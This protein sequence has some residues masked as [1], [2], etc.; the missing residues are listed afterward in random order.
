MSIVWALTAAVAFVAGGVAMKYSVGLTRPG[1]SLL[2]FVLFCAGAA[3]QTLAMRHA[4][5][6]VTY[7]VVLG[8]ESI[9]AFGA[10]VLV[11][12][13]PATPVRILAAALVAVGVML[14]RS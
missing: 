9:L 1:P 12:S 6:S 8:L 14:L 7:L 3:A 5:M 11:F 10:G 4:E 2:L 13:E